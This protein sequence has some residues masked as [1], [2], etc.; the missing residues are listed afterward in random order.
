MQRETQEAQVGA[1]RRLVAEE[2]EATRHRSA[3]KRREAAET[4]RPWGPKPAP[5]LRPTLERQ[6]TQQEWRQFSDRWARYKTMALEPHSYSVPQTTNELWFCCYKEAQNNLQNLGITVTSTEEE[7]LKKVKD[8][9]VKTV[10]LLLNLC[11]FFKIGHKEGEG[12][13]QYLAWL[14]GAA[15]GG[16]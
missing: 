4:S 12:L 2:A 16:G 10:N 7:I 8:L 3:D 6:I 11:K 9:A 13:R 15:E 1:A 5:T 14:K